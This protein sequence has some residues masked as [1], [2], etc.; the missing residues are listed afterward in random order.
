MTNKNPDQ[1]NGSGEEFKDSNIKYVLSKFEFDLYHEEDNKPEPVI[2]VKRIS[3]GKTEKWKIF[4]DTK[5]IFILEGIKL[6]NKEK[7]FLRTPDGFNFLI[8]QYKSG[9]KS[10]NAVKNEIKKVLTPTKK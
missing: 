3:V 4:A 6:G 8:K 1:T 10:F 9:I 2:R 7:E 5:V